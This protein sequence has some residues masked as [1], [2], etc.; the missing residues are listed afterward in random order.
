MAASIGRELLVRQ[1]G[2]NL[3]GVRSKG[4]SWGGEPVDI[5][6]DD[7]ASYRTLLA[8]IS[9]QQ[10]DLSVEGIIKDTVLRDQIL[11]NS[12]TLKLSNIDVV[13]PNSDTITGDFFIASYEETGGY[14]DAVTF[15][16]SLQS[17][18]EWTFTSAP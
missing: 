16:C 6:T 10:I 7:E 3:L 17:S 8:D 14:Q 11:N 4:V 9:Q 13:F 18:G 15:T 2:T 1:G 5:T 12:G